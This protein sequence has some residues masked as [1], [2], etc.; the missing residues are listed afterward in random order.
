MKKIVTFI[1]FALLVTGTL[2][3][4]PT[5]AS[6]A[7]CRLRIKLDAPSGINYAK[8][9]VDG[10]YKGYVYTRRYKTVRVAAGR[11]HSVMATRKVGSDYYK[12]S[13]FF[14]ISSGTRRKSITVRILKKSGGRKATLRL[15][16]SS[17]TPFRTAS[18]YV[19]GSY[20]G[21]VYRTRTRSFQVP[22]GTV[23]VRL[24]KR[25]RGTTYQYKRSIYLSRGRRT[26]RIIRMRSADGDGDSSGGVARIRVKL[27]SSSRVAR[28][29]LYINGRYKGRIYRSSYRTF[30]V[31]AGRIRVYCRRTYRGRRYRSRTRRIRVYSGRRRYLILRPRTSRDDDEG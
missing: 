8:L 23:R 6:A 3:A 20:K 13:N 11:S 12:G 18:L 1:V 2:L 25:Y 29:S 26:F 21:V 27:S 7:T 16:L 4:T 9:Y 15:R 19:N 10:R 24:R 31:R 17:S 28:A 5:D 30:R 14:S 22:S